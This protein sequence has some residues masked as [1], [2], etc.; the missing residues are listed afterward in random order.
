M[1]CK[2]VIEWAPG[3]EQAGV[4]RN[5]ASLIVEN[6][7]LTVPTPIAFEDLEELVLRYGAE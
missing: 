7:A 3:S 2:T 5:L 4:Y 1:H 6:T